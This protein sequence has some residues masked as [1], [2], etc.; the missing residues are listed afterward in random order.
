MLVEAA[1]PRGMGKTAIFT[2]SIQ[3]PM[4]ALTPHL[5]ITHKSGLPAVGLRAQ[6]AVQLPPEHVGNHQSSSIDTK[7][8]L[9][10]IPAGLLWRHKLLIF[11]VDSCL[12]RLEHIKALCDS[13]DGRMLCRMGLNALLPATGIPASTRDLVRTPFRAKLPNR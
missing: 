4:S 11:L 3:L 1:C 10:I 5:V 12:L 13:R 7:V 2:N 9:L 8:N 6:A